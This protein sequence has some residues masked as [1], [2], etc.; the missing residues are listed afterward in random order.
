MPKNTRLFNTKN[1]FKDDPTTL[2]GKEFENND[3][4]ERCLKSSIN[5][6]GPVV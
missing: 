4:R 3:G 5:C 6:F 2:G 1:T